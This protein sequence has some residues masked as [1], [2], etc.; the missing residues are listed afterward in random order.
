MVVED[1]LDNGSPLLSWPHTIGH[2]IEVTAG[3]GNHAGEA[4]AVE[5][6]R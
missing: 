3:Y 2:A 4:V 6:F 1:E 5:W